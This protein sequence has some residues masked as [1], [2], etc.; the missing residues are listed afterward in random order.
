MAIK[1]IDI[2][3]KKLTER[4]A[5]AG[6]KVI[7]SRSLIKKIKDGRLPKGDC[8]A[9]AQLAGIFA[10][11]NTPAMVPLC[12]P[13][14][15]AYVDIQFKFKANQLEIIS[16]VKAQDATGVEM[17]ALAACSVAALTIY[18]MA[19]TE[20][21]NIVITDLKLLKKTGGKSGDYTV[22]KQ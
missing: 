22:K 16:L 20:E 21:K 6:V 18:D 19:K 12:H 8:L 15:L 14:R 10:A 2:S 11:K 9:A 13:I 4:T 17:E 7:A 1:M 3:G 5:T